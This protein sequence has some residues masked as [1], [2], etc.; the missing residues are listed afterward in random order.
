MIVFEPGV[1]RP[2][3]LKAY[4]GKENPPTFFFKA[5]SARDIIAPKQI[6]NELIEAG[7]VT[8]SEQ[9]DRLIDGICAA[10]VG[11]EFCGEECQYQP[12]KLAEICTINELFELLGFVASDGLTYSDKKKLESQP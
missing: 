4:R 3:V 8:T 1:K 5:L 7:D 12:E 2:F 6:L 10:L 9:L 11:W